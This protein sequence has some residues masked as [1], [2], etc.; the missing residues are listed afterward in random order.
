MASS[1]AKTPLKRNIAGLFSHLR[2]TP[3]SRSKNDCGTSAGG[4]LRA[5]I[6]QQEDH[7]PSQASASTAGLDARPSVKTE[8]QSPFFAGSA[9]VKQEDG[10][11]EEGGIGS[12]SPS[13]YVSQPFD[14]PRISFELIALLVFLV[15]RSGYFSPA[16]GPSRKR[17]AETPPPKS[18]DEDDS[19]M[20][21]TPKKVFAPHRLFAAPEKYQHL[22]FVGDNLSVLSLVNQCPLRGLIVCRYL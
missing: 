8:K 15:C 7:D 19:L 11:E 21:V 13:K 14:R 22:S 5:E 18:E 4:R 9:E 1:S 3:P 6:D 20:Q 10:E 12:V 17:K 16:S 2:Y